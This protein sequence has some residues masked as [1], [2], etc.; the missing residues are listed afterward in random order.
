MIKK[1]KVSDE[2]MKTLTEI[3]TGI[4][5]NSEPKEESDPSEQS[6]QSEQSEP[7]A[8]EKKECKCF[9]CQFEK[10]ID[11]KLEKMDETNEKYASI[12]ANIE[13]EC[14]ERVDDWMD[15]YGV[16]K[17]EGEEIVR[18]MGKL[19]QSY[20]IARISLKIVKENIAK[21]SIAKNKE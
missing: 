20:E 19:V 5:N 10:A 15:F 13:R 9:T 12:Q 3:L 1:I 8:K 16:C 7:I 4:A 6:E 18:E 11:V 2:E 21:L 17:S 14:G